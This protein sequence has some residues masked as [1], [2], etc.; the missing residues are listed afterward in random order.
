M[1]VFNATKSVG[2]GSEVDLADDSRSR[3][4][5]LLGRNSLLPGQGLWIV[6]C[7]AIHTF[8]MQFMIDVVFLNRKRKILKIRK[9]MPTRRVAMCLRAYSTLELPAGTLDLTGTQPGD[10]L[11]F[12]R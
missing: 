6:P 11:E 1:R 2:V 7:E 9:S 4:R 3:R 8:G 12:E 5:G 10:V